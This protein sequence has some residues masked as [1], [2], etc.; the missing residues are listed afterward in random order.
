MKFVKFG[1]PP[2]DC[3]AKIKEFVGSWAEVP[4]HVGTVIKCDC[5]K[6]YILTDDGVGPTFWALTYQWQ[7]DL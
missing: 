3:H 5:E 4:I 1:Q 2:C 6:K 7:G